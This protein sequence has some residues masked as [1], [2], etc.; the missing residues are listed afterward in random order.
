MFVADLSETGTVLRVVTM[1]PATYTY[2]ITVWLA[3]NCASP[4][5]DQPV[6]AR[7]QTNRLVE[8]D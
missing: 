1:A 3:E 7:R 6:I 5:L 8:G 2:A 4:T